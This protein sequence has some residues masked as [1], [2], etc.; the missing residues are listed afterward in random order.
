MP[1]VLANRAYCYTEL[2][3]SSVAAAITIA[4]TVFAYPWR[5]GQAELAWVAWSNTKMVYRRMVIHLNTNPAQRWEISLMRPMLLPLGHAK[6]I[7]DDVD[8][9]NANNAYL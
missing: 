3:V 8:E 7:Y 4:S 1:A 2:A 5:D 9:R 6:P